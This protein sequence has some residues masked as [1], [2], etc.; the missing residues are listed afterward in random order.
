[1][2]EPTASSFKNLTILFSILNTGK[3]SVISYSCSFIYLITKSISVKFIRQA[4][5]RDFLIKEI[6]VMKFFPLKKRDTKLYCLHFCGKQLNNNPCQQ[7]YTTT[8]NKQNVI[9]GCYI[10]RSFI[11]R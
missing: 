11:M 9:N 6:T 7:I 2:F 1:M 5:N 4:F 3:Y 10:A 8:Y